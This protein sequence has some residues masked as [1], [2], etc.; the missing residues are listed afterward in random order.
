MLSEFDIIPPL[1]IYDCFSFFNEL[2]VLEIRLNTLCS[3][4]DKFVL[5][6]APWTHTGRP[7]PLIFENNKARFAPFLEKIVHIVVTDDDLP[8][9]PAGATEREI[10]WIR[11][12]V[13]RNAIVKGLDGAQ[14]DDVLIISDLDEIPNPEKVLEAA[15]APRGITNLNLR[16]YAFFLN[17]RN[18][19]NPDWAAGPQLLTA[20]AFRDAATYAKS[21]FSEYAPECANPLPSA[22]LI[23]F[24]PKKRVIKDAGWHF[25][26]MGGVKAIIEKSRSF[27]HN[28]FTLAEDDEERIRAALAAGRSPLPGGDRFAAEPLSRGFPSFIT[29]NVPHLKPLTLETTEAAY[30]KT[31]VL[32]IWAPLKK[33][34]YDSF[35]AAAIFI[36]PKFLHPTFKAVRKRLGI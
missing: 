27:A 4:V 21:T 14:P 10:A 5:V 7:K 29:G 31:K 30:R 23:R 1:M 19:S 2:D 20:A 35:V 25:S 13:Q 33:K 17:N 16:N 15:K 36:V 9:F 22:T 24:L 3:V 28:E 18:I 34:A 32:R 8:Q 26:Y 12:N 6:E 11:E